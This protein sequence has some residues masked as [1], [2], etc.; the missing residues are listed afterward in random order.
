MKSKE[1]TYNTG[2]EEKIHALA[3]QELIAEG[4]MR[5]KKNGQSVWT[6]KG[7]IDAWKT[8]LKWNIIMQGALEKAK[9]VED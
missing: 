6:E 5:I 1:D 7:L 8:Y 9:P 4:F 2:T 3:E